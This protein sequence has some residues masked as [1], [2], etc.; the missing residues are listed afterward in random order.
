MREMDRLNDLIRELE[1]QK[2]LKS[3]IGQAYAA[4]G[5]VLEYLATGHDEWENTAGYFETLKDEIGERNPFVVE[6]DNDA[7]YQKALKFLLQAKGNDLHNIAKTLIGDKPVGNI[8]YDQ[9]VEKMKS[10]LSDKLG[11]SGGGAH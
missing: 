3:K 5:P 10:V 8:G 6:G 4:L 9:A 2:T 1:R 11:L 7:T